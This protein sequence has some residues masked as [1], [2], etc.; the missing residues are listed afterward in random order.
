MLF[1]SRLDRAFA[2]QN[3]SAQTPY[4]TPPNG[5]PIQTFPVVVGIRHCYYAFAF[6]LHD[7]PILSTPEFNIFELAHNISFT[8]LRQRLF[9]WMPPINGFKHLSQCLTINLSRLRFNATIAPTSTPSSSPTAYDDI[10]NVQEE[11]VNHV[12]RM[13]DRDGSGLLILS[14]IVHPPEMEESYNAVIDTIAAQQRARA[15]E[16]QPQ[17]NHF[18]GQGH[19]L[20]TQ[21]QQPHAGSSRRRSQSQPDPSIQAQGP[22][23]FQ[24][25]PSGLPNFVFPGPGPPPMFP[26][27]LHAPGDDSPSLISRSDPLAGALGA[28]ASARRTGLTQ[29]PLARAEASTVLSDDFELYGTDSFLMGP[30]FGSLGPPIASSDQDMMSENMAL[31]N[32]FDAGAAV[33]PEGTAE[34][35]GEFDAALSTTAVNNDVSGAFGRGDIAEVGTESGVSKGK[36]KRMS[37]GED[38]AQTKKFKEE[39]EE[40]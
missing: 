38:V 35:G 1:G 36:R 30:S 10:C 22:A 18:Q 3:F 7:E 32:T 26:T 34:D 29:S 25:P 19:S 28:G 33:G 20:Q 21:G 8:D 2:P 40:Q 9:E 15:R 5:L 37:E 16:F 14:T 31:L 6:P 13:L 23:S 39:E 4:P 12:I 11:N 24:F 17:P 27:V